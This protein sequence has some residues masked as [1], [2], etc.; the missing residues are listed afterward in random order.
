MGA[1]NS[2]LKHNFKPD[3]YNAPQV[4]RGADGNYDPTDYQA[5]LTV[6]SWMYNNMPNGMIGY[7]TVMDAARL[8]KE[9]SSDISIDGKTYTLTEQ[10]KAA[11]RKFNHDGLTLFR[12][13]DG[14]HNGTHDLVMGIWDID[15]AIKNGRLH[16]AAEHS[17]DGE[18]RNRNSEMPPAEAAK[19]FDDY[20]SK[21]LGG[22]WNVAERDLKHIANAHGMY[23]STKDGKQFQMIDDP[24]VIRAASV[25][26]DNWG[27]VQIGEGNSV[28]MLSQEE[29]QKL[30]SL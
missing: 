21:R 8:P 9:G 30:M 15:A 2:S 4:K 18:W 16:G 12:R 17:P 24:Q 10:D 23:L 3:D 1:V 7:Q 5:A 25:L 27:E 20:A 6:R 11:F 22:S 19:I 13:L 28:G 14:G 26:L 29:L